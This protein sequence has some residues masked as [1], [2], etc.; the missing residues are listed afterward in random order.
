MTTALIET[1][2]DLAA[3]PAEC[4]LVSE[5]PGY[6]PTYLTTVDLGDGEIMYYLTGYGGAWEAAEAIDEYGPFRVIY[7]PAD[8][9][10]EPQP[11]ALAMWQRHPIYLDQ[12]HG[13]VWCNADGEHIDGITTQ[14]QADAW[15]DQHWAAVAAKEA[16]QR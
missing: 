3:L 16:E 6:G 2:A 13:R 7:R 15:R 11:E 4:F 10:P 9:A 8:T 5:R 1:T 14:A 12:E